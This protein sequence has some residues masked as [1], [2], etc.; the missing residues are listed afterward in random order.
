MLGFK[1]LDSARCTLCGIELMHMIEKS[2]MI[3][4]GEQKLSAAK[5][6]YSLAA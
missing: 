2:Q 1:T 3:A 4:T 5:Q 6:F